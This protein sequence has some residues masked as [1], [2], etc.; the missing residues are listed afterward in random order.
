MKAKLRPAFGVPLSLSLSIVQKAHPLDVLTLF[1]RQ[2][3]F[4][5]IV[6]IADN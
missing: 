1:I 2:D 6:T 4:E 3:F 5:I